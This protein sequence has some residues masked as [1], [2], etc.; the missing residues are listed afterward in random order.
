MCE[1]RCQGFMYNYFWISS[2]RIVVLKVVTISSPTTQAHVWKLATLSAVRK[3]IVLAAIRLTATATCSA[4]IWVIAAMILARS[5]NNV[6][7]WV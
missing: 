7:F 4:T 3:G 2:E 1:I 6:S 5:A